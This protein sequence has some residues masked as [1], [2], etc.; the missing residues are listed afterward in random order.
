MSRSAVSPPA[1][2]DGSGSSLFAVAAACAANL[3]FRRVGRCLESF[4]P[5]VSMPSQIPRGPQR[6]D[7]YREK[8][9][10]ASA[11]GSRQSGN[12]SQPANSWSSLC[13]SHLCGPSASARLNSYG[14][15]A[16]GDRMPGSCVGGITHAA[17]RRAGA[18][19]F[20]AATP[21][22][23]GRPAKIGWLLQ[24]TEMRPRRACTPVRGCSSAC[25]LEHAGDRD[26]A[27]GGEPAQPLMHG[28]VP[29]E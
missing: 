4:F 19:Q 22:G 16:T 28:Q 14:P 17:V 13:T 20:L 21:P 27:L 23:F 24:E 9:G 26:G 7:E 8:R 11:P 5:A 6:Y 1:S 29:P 10:M 18:S 12:Q 3:C 25:N 15:V 2:Q